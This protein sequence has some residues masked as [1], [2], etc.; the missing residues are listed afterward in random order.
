[1]SIQ[2]INTTYVGGEAKQNNVEHVQVVL[3]AA[4]ANVSVAAPIG[5]K[6]VAAFVQSQTTTDALNTITLALTNQSNSGA[7]MIA[8]ALYDD[9]PSITSNTATQLTLSTTDANLQADL[10]DNLELAYTVVGTVAGGVVVLYF[11]TDI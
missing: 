10:N 8:S 2:D 7:S 5:G 6:L 1:M 9:S 3:G 11:Q 4:S